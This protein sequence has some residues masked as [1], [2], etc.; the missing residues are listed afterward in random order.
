M[1]RSLVVVTN[2]WV[3][4]ELNLFTS[5]AILS[6]FWSDLIWFIR[7]V[8]DKKEPATADKWVPSSRS[9]TSRS[10]I[11]FSSTA[12][13]AGCSIQI[14]QKCGLIEDRKFELYIPPLFKDIKVPKHPDNLLPALDIA[15]LTTINNTPEKKMQ[16]KIE[17][18]RG[19]E[20]IHNTFL[21]GQYGIIV[22]RSDRTNRPGVWQVQLL[23]HE[24][25]ERLSYWTTK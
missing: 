16:R 25:I 6:M 4:F 20:T 14:T 3:C 5:K 23:G 9:P 1:K 13:P 10:L 18:I 24:V 2:S 17:H 11:H 12:I 8:I 7:N 19:P 15:P 21:H 22:S